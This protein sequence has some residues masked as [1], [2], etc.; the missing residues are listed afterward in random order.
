[1][2]EGTT[3]PLHEGGNFCGEGATVSNMFLNLNNVYDLQ[4]FIMATMSDK[5]HRETLIHE[6][7]KDYLD[8]RILI[9]KNLIPNAQKTLLA[10]KNIGNNI[11]ITIIF[12]DNN[13]NII[14][15]SDNIP[16]GL[17]ITTPGIDNDISN[18]FNGNDSVFI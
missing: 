4:N 12:L 3:P 15:T 5:F 16:C 7:T 8:T 9:E 18:L 17:E 1:M 10:K 6:L 13:G 2:V 14:Y 11:L